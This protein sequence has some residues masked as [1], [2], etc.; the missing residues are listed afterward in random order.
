MAR[1]Y[2]KSK[3]IKAS[4]TGSTA[5]KVDV[6]GIVKGVIDAIRNGGDTAVRQYS[7]KFDKWSPES[8]KL[9][10]ADI[11]RIISSLPKQTIDDIKK[12][13]SN[14]RRFAE[15]QKASMR[16]IEVEMEPGVF[17]GHKNTP[18]QRVGA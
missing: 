18:I 6:P 14:V 7:E 15:A 8:F 5:P 9:S 11:D 13:Q 2:L 12:V 1:K 10:E 16:E 17:L 3:P 4:A